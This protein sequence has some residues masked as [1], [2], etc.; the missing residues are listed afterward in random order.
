MWAHH[1]VFLP[2]LQGTQLHGFTF[3]SLD[4]ETQKVVF[5]KGKNLFPDEQILACKS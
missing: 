3:A 5:F 1:H 4:D 2:V